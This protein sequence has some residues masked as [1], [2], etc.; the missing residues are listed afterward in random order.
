MIELRQL[1]LVRDCAGRGKMET[2]TESE[3]SFAQWR[4]SHYF[5]FVAHNDKNI[6][7]KCTVCPGDRQLSTSAK[8]MSNL[9]KNI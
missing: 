6:R 5:E 7:V 2:D 8:S 9:A 1:L 3:R 4:Y